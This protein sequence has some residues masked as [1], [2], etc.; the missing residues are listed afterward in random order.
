MDHLKTENQYCAQNYK[1]LPVVL[2]RGEGVWLWDD[3][4]NRYLD[5]MSA[6]SAVSHGHSNPKLVEVLTRQ[7][8]RLAITSRAF[9]NDQLGKFLE[10]LCKVSG[11]D[12]AL[13]MNTGAEAVETAIKAARRWGYRVKGIPAGQAEIIVADQNFHG[14]TTTIISFSSEVDYKADFGPLTR[15]FTTVPFGDADALEA[16]ITPHTC[17]VLMEPIQGEA[18][19]RVPPQ[20]WLRRVRDICDRHN[21]L[22]ILDE[23]Q[24]GLGRTGR[25]FAFQHEAIKPDAITLGKALGGGLL[26]VSAFLARNEVMDVFNS[27]SHGSTFGGNPLAAAVAYESLWLLEEGRL[28]ERSAELGA[29]LMDGLKE[30]GRD[31]FTDVRGRGLWVGVDLDPKFMSASTLCHAL[32]HQGI[33]T[34]ETHDRTIRF[35]PPLIIRQEEIDWALEKISSVLASVREVHSGAAAPTSPELELA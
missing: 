27:G 28:P 31:I 35:A 6:Y 2:T 33:L 24:S 30:V 14:R 32:M 11:F 8:S 7:A 19:I 12:K 34:K 10:K 18:G 1:P 21:V 26:P 20:G 5:M 3:K 15:G 16:A 17:A 29:Y 9:H 13:P 4:G 25:M 22:L 23:I